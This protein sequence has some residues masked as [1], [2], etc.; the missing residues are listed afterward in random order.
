[1]GQQYNAVSHGLYAKEALL[2][3]ENRRQYLRFCRELVKSLAP[4]NEIQSHLARD[5]AED[6]WKIAR[7]DRTINAMQEEIFA[8]LTPDT[9]CEVTN[10][11]PPLRA[12]APIWL[13]N[14]SHKIARKEKQLH[15]GVCKQYQH[16]HDNFAS[17]PNLVAVYKQYPDLF[18]LASQFAQQDGKRAILNAA[19]H[20]LD[21]AWQ[22]S[23]K[24]LWQ[25]LERAYHHS[26]FY[27]HWDAIR[28]E[29]HPWIE[30]WYFIQAG[31]NS[32]LQ[33]HQALALKAR[34]DFRKQL[35]AYER[36]KKN[37]ILFSATLLN[38]SQND[39]KDLV[40]SAENC[41]NTKRN[42]NITTG[43]LTSN[44]A[45]D[46]AKTGRSQSDLKPSQDA[47]VLVNLPLMNACL[48]NA[49]AKTSVQAISH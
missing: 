5:I 14:M 44:E 47:V 6:A 49:L 13:V 27:A 24:A 9:V 20:T 32:R 35:Q 1:M 42:K 2:P 48:A 30:A 45:S 22:Q 19:T 18:A 21:S 46:P 28:K 26:Y 33:N 10:V 7:I 3:F 31:Q 16:C 40:P 39:S 34:A 41:F 8:C 12:A 25:M 4:E 15:S 43:T 29:A 38:Y 17:V 36:L 37:A 23:T 11:P